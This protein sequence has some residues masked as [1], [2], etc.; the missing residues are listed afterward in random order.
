MVLHFIFIGA[1]KVSI[2][3]LQWH[4]AYIALLCYLK[5][6]FPITHVAH[7]EA[8]VTTPPAE[9]RLLSTNSRTLLAFPTQ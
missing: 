2:I 3:T 7:A 5:T 6:P 9:W 1:F 8:N 4:V